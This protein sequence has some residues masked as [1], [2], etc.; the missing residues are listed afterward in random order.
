MDLG[1]GGKSALVLASSRGLGLGVAQ[2]LAAE[3]AIVT[4]IGRDQVRLE[5]ASSAINARGGGRASFVRADLGNPADMERVLSHAKAL[6]GPDI[7]INNSG[8]PPPSAASAVTRAE[9]DAQFAAMATPIFEVTRQSV[10]EMRKKKWGRIV[11][12]ASSGVIQPIPD[13]PVS[14]ALR[15]SIVAWS[16]TLATEVA[17]DGVTA[18]IVVPGRIATARVAQLDE[19]AAARAQK[20]VEDV[21]KASFATIPMGRYGEVEEFASVVAFL[22]GQP[23]SYITGSIIRVDGGMIRS[24]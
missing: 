3:G 7:L 9:W 22:A 18:N 17:A 21:R 15:A 8:G 20:P 1:I 13:L 14:N 11:T 5:Q 10:V 19:A 6:G 4:L 16:K 23:A 24:I 2:A 12:I